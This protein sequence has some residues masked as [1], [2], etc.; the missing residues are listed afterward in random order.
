[1]TVTNMH[2]VISIKLGVIS[3]VETAIKCSK[4]NSLLLLNYLISFSGKV[5]TDISKFCVR[6]AR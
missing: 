3:N 2:I 1:M 5:S 4:H 6:A